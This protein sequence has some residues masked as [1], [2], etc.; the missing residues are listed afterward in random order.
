MTS[1]IKTIEPK[2]D[3]L[4]SDDLI[5]IPH[6]IIKVTK[7]TLSAGDQPIS[8]HYEDDNGKPYKPC[9][10][11]RRVL[12]SVWGVDGNSF[13][14]KSMALY[15]DEKVTWAGVAVGGIRI[16]HMSHI[17][18]NVTMAL[19]ATKSSRKP[20]TVKPLKDTVSPTQTAK[21]EA[22]AHQDALI[23]GA[24]GKPVSSKGVDPLYRWIR[25]NGEVLEYPA[26]NEWETGVLKGIH[27]L[28]TIEYLDDA[29]N[30]NVEILSGMQLVA[31]D[32][33]RAARNVIEIINGRIKNLNP[34]NAG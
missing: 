20:Y 13:I 21:G 31:G 30:R 1:L 23:D 33:Q 12:V 25:S 15:R 5:G 28:K 7:V 3:Q 11:M 26:I 10:S 14:G 34:L 32:A 18:Q 22:V 24:S 17:D 27:S 19:T 9:K 8:I 2:S 16:S 6:K 29:Y 4:N